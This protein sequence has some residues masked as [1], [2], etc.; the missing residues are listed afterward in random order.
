[1]KADFTQ[2]EPFITKETLKHI[3]DNVPMPCLLRDSDYNWV[4]SNKEVDALFDIKKPNQ[5]NYDDLQ[6]PYQPDGCPSRSKFRTLMRGVIEQGNPITIDW[7]HCRKDLELVP[8]EVTLVRVDVSGKPHIL[9]FM[10]DMRES[11]QARI[12]ERIA[13]QRLQ[14]MMDSCPMACG[15][16]DEHF[17]VLECNNEVVN[18]FGILNKQ[19]FIERFFELSPEYQPD[20]QLSRRKA[21]DKLKQTFE[22][23]RTHYEWLHQSIYG[24]QI[25]SEVTL[26]RVNLNEQDL[27]IIYIHDLREIKRSIAMMEKMQSIAYTDELTELFS[28]RYFMENAKTILA[29][30]KA[31]NDPFHLIMMDLDHFKGINDTYGHPIGDEV[32][33]VAA[34]RMTNVTRKD[35]II[36]RYGGEEFIVLLTDLSYE[37]AVKNAQRIQK[38]MEE[39]PFMIKGMTLNVTVSLGI[40]TLENPAD[41]LDEIIHNADIA[42][43]GAK[44]TGRNKVMEY[45]HAKELE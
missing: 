9:E 32:L 20:G 6:P 3:I 16:I 30:S 24:E 43:Y 22:A 41:S 11:T 12:A 36:A 8:T 39:S 31:N 19:S 26:V 15:I 5:V 17:N 21:L 4:H 7:L 13:K 27:A 29:K 14:A 34:K 35:T 28:R 18:L 44:R 33:K 37:S 1:M 42:L 10:Q 2:I 23:G 40:A 45:A 25:P 38:V